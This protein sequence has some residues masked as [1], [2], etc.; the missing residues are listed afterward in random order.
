M[1]RFDLCTSN[2]SKLE[3]AKGGKVFV[4]AGHQSSDIM[5]SVIMYLERYITLDTCIQCRVVHCEVPAE[6]RGR[7]VRLMCRILVQLF[8]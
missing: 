2:E 5:S 8:L 7:S 1:F 3:I 4:R 6:K